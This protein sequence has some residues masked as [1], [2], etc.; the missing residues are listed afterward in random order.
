MFR[1][2]LRRFLEEHVVPFHREWEKQGFVPKDVW[3]EAGRQGFLLPTVPTEYGGAGG[4]FG[5]SAVVLEEVARVNAT[6]LGFTLQSDV[7]APY[8]LQYGN[9][10]LKQT[11]L[12]R[13]ARGEVIASLAITEPGAGS[14]VKAIRTT[15]VRDGD[16]YIINGNKTFITNGFNSG[17]VIVTAKTSPELGHK[18]VSLILVPEGTPGFSKGR[19]LEKIGLLAQ[20]TAELFF[21]DVRVPVTNLLGE[22]NRGFYYLMSNLAQ[23]R[24]TI[25]IRAIA[26]I[27]A[28]LERAIDYTRER[29]VFGNP[30]FD[31]QTTKFKLAEVKAYAAMLR[32]FIDDCLSDHLRDALSHDRAAMAKLVAT[33]MQGRILDDLLQL[34]GG[35]GYMSEYVIG[36]AWLDARV[37]RIYGGS[38]EI[39]KEIIS[40]TL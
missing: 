8:I 17:L 23:E 24:L 27:E 35:Y 2:Q 15:A 33:E 11:W 10:E 25:A 20:D 32:T 29:K 38:S 19:K 28:M 1:D 26:S 14:D 13:M 18:G 31:F 36:R 30:L 40:R 9:E 39:M 37:M 22:E 4:D 6:G 12:P 7:A 5:F 34:Y 21:Q 16:D 3:L